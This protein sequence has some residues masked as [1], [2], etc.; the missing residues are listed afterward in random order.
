MLAEVIGVTVKMKLGV[1][2]D[3]TPPQIST[4]DR[5]HARTADPTH[6]E[7]KHTITPDPD[8]LRFAL[9]NRYKRV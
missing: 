9:I 5:T 1:D 4:T 2:L 8:L 7:L 6:N 3:P